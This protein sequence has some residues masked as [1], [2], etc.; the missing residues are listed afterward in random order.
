MNFGVFSGFWY[1]IELFLPEIYK[2]RIIVII[3]ETNLLIWSIEQI[4]IIHVN[5]CANFFIVP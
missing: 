5:S 3:E 2:L 1:I 4:P